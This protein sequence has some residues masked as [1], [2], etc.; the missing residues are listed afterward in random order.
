MPGTI[1]FDLFAFVFP[2]L[3]FRLPCVPVVVIL[4]VETSAHVT[5]RQG[6][7]SRSSLSTCSGWRVDSFPSARWSHPPGGGISDHFQLFHISRV[8]DN[9]VCTWRH[10][11]PLLRRK[12]RQWSESGT[13]QNA[14]GV[15]RTVMW[16]ERPTVGWEGSSR[17]GPA[18]HWAQFGTSIK[19][20]NIWGSFI[21]P[22]LLEEEFSI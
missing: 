1:Q 9:H 22:Q 20:P 5:S 11:V 19:F 21:D 3:F 14:E 15:T 13:F 6:G 18:A 16:F 10:Y 2:F 12:W 4:L 7:E 17:L 8:C